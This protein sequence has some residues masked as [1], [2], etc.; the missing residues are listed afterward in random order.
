MLSLVISTVVFFMA[1]YFIKQYLENMG[2]PKGMTRGLVVFC[3]AILI[4]YGVAWIVDWL[5]T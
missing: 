2:I 5:A 1:A 4:S 3:L